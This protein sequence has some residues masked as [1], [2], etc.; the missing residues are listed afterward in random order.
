MDIWQC[1]TGGVRIDRVLTCRACGVDF[2]PNHVAER[3][4]SYTCKTSP[5]RYGYAVKSTRFRI[6]T[7]DGFRCIYCGLTAPEDAAAL[8][9]D[10]IVPEASG[11]AYAPTNLVTACA[12]CNAGKSSTRLPPDVEARIL[13]VVALREI[14]RR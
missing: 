6:L 5:E 9:V 4:C 7:R 2:K 11:G 8:H 3:Y 10:H 12:D 14:I 13:A 1:R